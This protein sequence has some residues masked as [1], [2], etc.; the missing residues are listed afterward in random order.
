MT[1]I[2]YYIKNR[3]LISLILVVLVYPIVCIQL[4]VMAEEQ[5]I[6]D[7]VINMYKK[8]VEITSQNAHKA[9]KL[10]EDGI[11]SKK[12]YDELLDKLD[13]T[14][15][16]YEYYKTGDIKQNNKKEN[17]DDELYESMVTL[18]NKGIIS[19]KELVEADYRNKRSILS[20]NSLDD[21]CFKL[22]WSS[23]PDPFSIVLKT[24]LKFV[25][26]WYG[27]RIHPVTGLNALHTGVDIAAPGGVPVYAYEKGMVQRSSTGARAGNLLKLHI[28]MAIVVC[29]YILIKAS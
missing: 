26:S 2:K 4:S 9:K 1:E 15:K 27:Y 17:E 18:Y 28:L 5:E 22:M 20:Y 10:L 19:Q 6:N 14:K 11:I 8:Q 29:I 16:L 3:I 7:K 23:L 21:S 25:S 12:E 24:P 13:K